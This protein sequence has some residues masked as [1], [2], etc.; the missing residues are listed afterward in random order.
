MLDGPVI[1]FLAEIGASVWFDE[2]DESAGGVYAPHTP[3]V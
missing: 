2:Y 1:K 3:P